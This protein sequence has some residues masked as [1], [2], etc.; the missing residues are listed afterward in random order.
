MASSKEISMEKAKKASLEIEH[1]R[2]QTISATFEARAP[3]DDKD[4]QRKKRVYT[5]D[6]SLQRLLD[7]G[8][9]RHPESVEVY[10][11]FMRGIEGKLCPE[12]R[13]L[14]DDLLSPLSSHTGLEQ[15]CFFGEFVSLA[16]EMPEQ[17]RL[18][19]YRDPTGLVFRPESVDEHR[20]G[21]NVAYY[22]KGENFTCTETRRF[23]IKRRRPFG[24]LT[25]DEFSERFTQYVFGRPYSQFP[26]ELREGPYQ[27]RIFPGMGVCPMGFGT[28]PTKETGI[29]DLVPFYD[30]GSRGVRQNAGI[31]ID[32]ICPRQHGCSHIEYR[33]DYC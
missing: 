17:D 15:L 30:R 4:A 23:R 27:I 1:N 32:I 25:P 24:P 10:N 16:M 8:F 19:V 13:R 22:T 26:K 7:A 2:I 14:F 11:L 18:L 20:N 28:G 29:F 5:Y 6:E 9:E 33:R 31:N 3:R 21:K 12:E